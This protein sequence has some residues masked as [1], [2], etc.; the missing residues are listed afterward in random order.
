VAVAAVPRAA[1]S[2]R[3]VAGN[4]RLDSTPAF[5]R[6][7]YA[8]IGHEADRLGRDAFRTRLL[9]R[10]TTCVRGA[11]LV[12]WFYGSEGLV[13]DGALPGRAQRTLVGR[14]SVQT[15]DGERHRSRKGLLL[16]LA[17]PDSVAG[18]EACAA[19]EWDLAIDRWS[20]QDGSWSST[21]WPRSCSSR[22]A[23]GCTCPSPSTDARRCWVTFWP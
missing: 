17:G 15:V 21:R 16:D 23:G 22:P 14:G 7:G 10:P 11:E 6:L 18:L 9:G 19:E 5:L 1:P 4:G 13:R 2:Q 12:E 20:R 8:F 3:P